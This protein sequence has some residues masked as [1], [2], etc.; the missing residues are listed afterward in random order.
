MHGLEFPPRGSGMPGKEEAPPSQKWGHPHQ[1][2]SS[3]DWKPG[4]ILLGHW[5]GRLLGR[6]DDR[7]MFTTA[8]TRGG[9]TSTV[10]EPNLKLYPGSSVVTD[11]KGDLAKATAEH[12]RRNGQQVAV[13]DSFGVTGM[14][15]ASYNP[16]LEL[17]FGDPAQIPADA[18]QVADALIVSND[19]DPHWTDSAKNLIRG[20][21]LYLIATNAKQASLREVRRLLCATM[22]ELERLFTEMA[23]STA[24]DGI[25]AN[26]GASFLGKLTGGPRELQGILSTAQE[27]TAPLDDMMGVLERSDFKL[28]D[29]RS[30]KLTIYLVLPGMRMVTHYRWLRLMV[31]QAL[32]AMERAP[33]PRGGQPVLFMLEEFPAL[34]HM[35]S[36]EA[37]AGLMAGYGVKLWAVIQDLSQLKT[38]YPRSWETFLGNAGIIQAFCN[39]DPTTTEFLS[40]MLGMTQVI[41][42]QEVRVTG[43]AMA[44]GDTGRR[45]NL[46]QVRLLDPY[47][48]TTHFARETGRQLIL[49]PGRPPIYMQRLNHEGGTQ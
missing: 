43:G 14:T 28:T 25:V 4:M 33:V 7:H 19:K 24:F 31:Q 41:E 18:A 29:L 13:L 46:R 48:I 36:I 12:R 22:P 17:G 44:H 9:K 32:A 40:K 35:K 49:T 26:I 3:W 16:L 23:D 8:A 34:G 5:E 1:L 37:A 6:A 20:I 38:H 2:G 27:Q 21:I 15:S 30:G 10:L 45:E 42:R 11:V 39:S 47:E